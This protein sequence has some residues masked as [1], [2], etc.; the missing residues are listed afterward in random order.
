MDDFLKAVLT[1]VL[2]F[3]AACIIMGL[4]R[5][6]TG[7]KPADRLVAVNMITTVVIMMTIILS[8]LFKESWLADIA[9][10]YALISFVAIIVFSR[11]YIVSRIK[12]NSG[13]D[14][15]GSP[16]SENSEKKLSQFGEGGS[17]DGN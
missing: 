2:F 8:V 1:V 4:I 9:A 11:L 12:R 7:K 16:A 3:L 17:N 15:D 13:E 14:T 10:I 6:F 5:A